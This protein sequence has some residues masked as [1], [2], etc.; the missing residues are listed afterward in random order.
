[1][2][3]KVSAFS[4]SVS[5]ELPS[6]VALN[7]D[8]SAA[9]G[10]FKLHDSYPNPFNPSTTVSY[11]I[12][13]PSVVILKVFNILG[14]EVATL[15]DEFQSAGTKTVRFDATGFA[16][17]MYLFRLQADRYVETRKTILTK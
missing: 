15:V 2:Q 17:G 4:D 1:M 3:N 7:S 5:V 9:S 16:S 12:P 14:Q 6:G 10:G 13:T 11:D 8:Q